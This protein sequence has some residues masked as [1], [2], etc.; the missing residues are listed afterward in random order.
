MSK[1]WL[2]VR[3]R[4]MEHSPAHTELQPLNMEWTL[5]HC[6]C[7]TMGG[8]ALQ[9]QDVWIYSVG[10]EDIHLLIQAGVI[11]CSDIRDRDIEDRPKAD[12]FAKGFTVFQS[13]WFLV[14]VIARWVRGIPVSPIEPTWLLV[15]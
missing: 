8:I 13:T 15:V 7:L 5:A 9:T 1:I 4:P 2:P 11:R 6:F 10:W 14:N 12:W 3:T